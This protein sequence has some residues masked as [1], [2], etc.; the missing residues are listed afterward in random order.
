MPIE[1][2]SKPRLPEPELLASSGALDEGFPPSGTPRARAPD[3][4]A[5][6]GQ[7]ARQAPFVGAGPADHVADVVVGQGG[8]GQQQRTVE[9]V[10]VER[11]PG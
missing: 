7:A 8:E 11:R 6:D 5:G 10:V 1:G 3:F 9:G 2:A 4:E